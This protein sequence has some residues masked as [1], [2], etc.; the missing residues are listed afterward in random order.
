VDISNFYRFSRYFSKEKNIFLNIDLD[1]RNSAP[2]FI[3]YKEN[4]RIERI[5]LSRNL[6]FKNSGIYSFK[7]GVIRKS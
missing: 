7:F 3:A 2:Q 6:D 5:H 4:E 1:L